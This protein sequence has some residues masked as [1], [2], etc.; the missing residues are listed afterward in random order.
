MARPP[1]AP[2]DRLSVGIATRN[3]AASLVRCVASLA[4]LGDLVSDIIVVDDSSDEPV[5]PA[6]DGLPADLLAKLTFITQPDQQGPIVA[7]NTMVQLARSEVVLLLDDDTL[8]VDERGIR[9]AFDLI[10]QHPD[11]GAVACAMAHADGS[12]WPS[13]MQ[14]SPAQYLS[15]VPAYIGFAHLLRRRVFLDLGSY[16]PLFYFYGE[17]KDYCLRLLNAGYHV[18]YDPDARVAHLVDPAG[19]SQAR[20]LRYVIRNDC[21]YSLYNE[22]LPLM[23]ATIPVRLYRYLKMSRRGNVRDPGGFRWIVAELTKA[24]PAVM[25]ERKPVRWSSVRRWRRLRRA[26]P[27]FRPELA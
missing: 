14:P 10:V 4:I 21:L 15:Y 19:R 7:R 12:P 5:R 22:P 9:R 20:Y 17:E 11:V 2:A 25:R 27:A 16:R 8:I 6:L 13:S 23:C 3:R 24:L 18:V 26:V 1:E